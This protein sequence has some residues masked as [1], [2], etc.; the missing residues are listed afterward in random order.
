MSL[1]VGFFFQ[2][3]SWYTVIYGYENEISYC[4]VHTFVAEAT[5][6]G[7][8]S[9]KRRRSDLY[10]LRKRF[11]G[12]SDCRWCVA[13]TFQA[14]CRGDSRSNLYILFVAVADP[15]STRSATNRLSDFDEDKAESAQSTYRSIPYHMQS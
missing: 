6:R 9:L 8:M 10:I 3:Y 15:F 1:S 11:K 4:C 14:I 2:I 12:L 5:C 7:D 13:Q